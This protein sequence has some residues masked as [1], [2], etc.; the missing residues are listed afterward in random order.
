[1]K[2]SFR[3]Q[4][5]AG[6]QVI[7]S[8]GNPTVEAEV[9]L[10][11]G[12][13]GRAIVPSGASTG[14]FEAIELRDGGSAFG[15]KGV[16]QAVTNVSGPIASALI[17]RDAIHQRAIDAMLIDLDGTENKSNLGANALLGVSMAVARACAHQLNLP[18]FRYIGGANACLLPVPM[19]NILNGGR[20][21]DNSVNLQEYMIMPEKATSFQEALRQCAEVFHAL[22][23]ELQSKSLATSVGDE[24]GFAPQLGSDEEALQ[25]I[26]AAIDRAGYTGKMGIA[27]DAAA[28]EMA[29]GDGTYE[30]WKSGRRF[31]RS[32]LIALWEDWVNR[33]PIVSIEDGLAEEDWEGWAELSE[34]LG[35]R[36]QLVGDDLFVTSTKRLQTGIDRNIANAI[37]IKLNQIGTLSETM[38][39]VHMARAH[40]YAAVISHRSGESEDP[41]IAD[42]AVALNAGQIKAGAPSRSDR[43]AKYN[44]LLRIEEQ[45]GSGA[46]YGIH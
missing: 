18:L 20:H 19:M 27:L 39:A 31:D 28:T 34:K 12:G 13:F 4:H 42:L 21:A 8:R 15:G 46:Q 32:E 33:Y 37:L 26:V 29:T 9:A 6:R 40:G 1:M 10:E 7:D 35:D 22:K 44:Q 24:G 25:A 5:V 30:F 3:I 17:G 41:F 14:A 16:L 38:D 2:Q 43:V 23:S 45:L 36:I 11:G